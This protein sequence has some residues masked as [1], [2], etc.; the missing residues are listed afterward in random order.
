MTQLSTGTISGS[1]L[2]DVFD[3][4]RSRIETAKSGLYS[5]GSPLSMSRQE[6][7][8]TDTAAKNTFY[9]TAL[10][11]YQ[12]ETAGL[13]AFFSAAAGTSTVTMTLSAYSL[14]GDGAAVSAGD[15]VTEPLNLNSSYSWTVTGTSSNAT[16]T[17]R[18]EYTDTSGDIIILKKNVQYKVVLSTTNSVASGTT[19]VTC[20]LDL[21]HYCRKVG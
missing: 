11:D 12:V 14:Y 8:S 10:D 2:N 19:V 4:Y 5:S 9:F 15:A 17:T 20:F 18:T 7:I 1:N 6:I 21:R 16:K 13:S 3:Q